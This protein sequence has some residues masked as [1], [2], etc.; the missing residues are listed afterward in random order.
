MY[1]KV[2]DSA[3]LIGLYD[4]AETALDDALLLDV[5][6]ATQSRLLRKKGLLYIRRGALDD[7]ATFL[8]HAVTILGELPE[9]QEA[10]RAWLLGKIALAGHRM[11]SGDYESAAALCT[12][13]VDA[14]VDTDL[15]AAERGKAFSSRASAMTH[16]PGKDGIADARSAL[17][18]FEKMK[19]LHNAAG[20]HNNLGYDAY[21][22]GDWD[23]CYESWS[24]CADI[25]EK[26]GDLEQTAITSLNIGELRLDQ[27]HLSEA[28][29]LLQRGLT[30]F[31]GA[32]HDI[33]IA[34]C[35]TN[36][37]RLLTRVGQFTEA[38]TLLDESVE[39]LTEA[40]ASGLLPEAQLRL[41]EWFLYQRD[42]ASLNETLDA[43]ASAL[44]EGSQAILSNV[45]RLRGYGHALAGD[46]AGAEEAFRTSLELA[47]DARHERLLA[48]EAIA[49]ITRV[50]KEDL[51]TTANQMGIVARPVS[52]IRA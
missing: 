28:M 47:V 19:D 23:D 46:T 9:D 42:I 12:D 2:S 43:C 29:A 18:E 49:R 45:A 41:G 44:P 52:P 32:K 39:L 11:R 5:I 30:I 24:T 6:P 40:G 34:M 25:S 7:G 15:F 21:Y 33:G 22:Q 27:G 37:G 1:E 26:I 13:V 48:L 36:L 14:A 17:V 3:A 4:Q 16:L 10:C 8:E 35:A 50:H 38:R 31:R 51:I 20:V